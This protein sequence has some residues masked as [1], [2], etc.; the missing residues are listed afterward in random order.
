MLPRVGAV[1]LEG[2]GPCFGVSRVILEAVH[3]CERVGVGAQDRH[4]ERR[5]MLVLRSWEAVEKT[6]F[7]SAAQ[8]RAPG[9]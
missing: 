9:K 8:C 7:A 1:R 6:S 5:K 2:W 4:G 3:H